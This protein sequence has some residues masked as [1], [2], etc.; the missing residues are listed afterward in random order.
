MSDLSPSQ[1]CLFAKCIIQIRE[2]DAKIRGPH[3]PMPLTKIPQNTNDFR[4][5]YKGRKFS[6]VSNIPTLSSNPNGSMMSIEDKYPVKIS[7]MMGDSTSMLRSR[8]IEE[9]TSKM[10][11][12]MIGHSW[13]CRKNKEN[14]L[15]NSRKMAKI[16]TLFALNNSEMNLI[17]MNLT[18]LTIW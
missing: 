1:E 5:I 11:E 17:H 15:R 14:L 3:Q 13:G 6:I 8:H 10:S 9:D 2:S 7:L 18:Q 16:G 12:K 4:S